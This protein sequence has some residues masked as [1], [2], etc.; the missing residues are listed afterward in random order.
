MRRCS[1]MS[2]IRPAAWA[3]ASRA[4]NSLAPSFQKEATGVPGSLAV[5][6]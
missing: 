1:L 6:E 4:K 5:G 2:Y 3:G